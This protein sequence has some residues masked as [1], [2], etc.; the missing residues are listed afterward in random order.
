MGAVGLV[1]VPLMCVHLDRD[2]YD[3]FLYIYGNGTLT[4][5]W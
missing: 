5:K 2:L 3:V 1:G 4:G